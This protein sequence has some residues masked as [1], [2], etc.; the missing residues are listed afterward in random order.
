MKLE[1]VENRADEALTWDGRHSDL[2]YVEDLSYFTENEVLFYSIP[3]T[4]TG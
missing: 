3:E 1:L 4:A 2:V